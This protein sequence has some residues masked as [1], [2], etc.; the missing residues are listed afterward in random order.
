ML[1][2]IIT[3]AFRNIIRNRTFSLINL[4][5]LSVSMS[6]GMLIIMIAKESFSYDKFHN[7]VDRLYRINTMAL[8]TNGEQE[9]YASTPYPLGT[10]I[11]ENYT[12][13]E[14]VVQLCRRLNGDA[15][16][17]N[18][19]VPVQGL[20]VD[21]AFL[22]VFNFPLDRGNPATA[23][24]EPNNVILT[25]ETAE[26]IFGKVEP[27]GQS[28]TI[29]GYGEF[30]VSGVLKKTD[31]KTHFEFQLL[32]STKAIPGFEKDE[33]I[34]PIQEDWNNYY[35]SYTYFK[36]KE[37]HTTSEV[38]TALKEI[39][40][41]YYSGLQLETRDRGY[42]FYLHPL[43]EITPG[44]AL[45]NQMGHGLPMF[46]LNFMI[47]LGAVVLL[48]SIFNFTNLMIAKSLGRA[49]EIGVRK[50]V[51]AQ[52]FQVFT[53]FVGETVVF[54]LFALVFSYL[55][56]QFLKTGYAQLDLNQEF[57][58]VFHEDWTLYFYF[59]VF[60]VVVGI[61]AG[62]LPSGYLSAF[63]PIQVLKDTASLKIYS[64]LTFRNILMITQFTF[65]VV[66]VTVILIIYNQVD[67]M[68]NADYGINQKN[69]LN[70]RLQGLAFEKFA[71]E[72]RSIQGVI[73]V[74]GVSHALG[75]WSDLS[76]DY[77]KNLE[78]KPF[79][80]RDFRVNDVY[81]NNLELQF[82]AGRNFDP[83]EQ[84]ENEKHVVL[85]E[86][87]LKEFQFANPIEAI[88]QPI[89]VDDSTMLTVIGVVKDFNF[90]PL[91]YQIGPLALRYQVNRLNFA[92]MKIASDQ[93]ENVLAGLEPIWK[94][95]DPVHPFEYMMMD[96]QIDDAYKQAG[97]D[98]ILIIV[99]YISFLT[100]TLACL[101]M[102]GMVMYATQIRIKEVGIRKVMGASVSNVVI[103]LS[104]SFL[105]LIGVAIV[106]GT[107]V[108]ILLGDF[109]LSQ[110]AYQID[111]SVWIVGS[112][113]SIIAGLGLLT[114]ASQTW[115]TAT[116]NP[117]KSLRY[118]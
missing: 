70:V 25:A 11:K 91:S 46:L 15:V 64:R 112:G 113:I 82:L 3:T 56:L 9:P 105:F 116:S 73:N 65:S 81:L 29:N 35:G 21:P 58:I 78:D 44:P 37:G 110:Y 31:N 76:S 63:K 80:M 52:R 115:S 101:G 106:L 22:T 24:A 54:S 36:L 75:T 14:D 94:K 89:Y 87:A 59:F 77:K 97:F 103:L 48:M 38:E 93:K 20:I 51:G 6:L 61:I 50:V 111:I 47:I 23:L 42:E 53:Q 13:A 99:G 100:L 108:S 45:S 34:R 68:L 60:A 107:P 84:G 88:G 26:R 109:F 39:V 4:V 67:Y 28:F 5:G 32:A 57:G 98:S 114:I 69:I 74:G 2:S 90:R 40:D 104:R 72:A 43:T 30:V 66:F 49:R 41:T 55:L 1:R 96:Q 117:V 95:L 8:R 16:Y 18:V 12:F 118:E 85:N 86:T 92:S 7:D 102:L 27:L 62:L 79:V 10:V 71:N 83:S 19:N 17:G 33:I